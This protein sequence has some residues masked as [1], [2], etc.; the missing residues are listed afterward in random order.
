LGK[1]LYKPVT[2][3]S[4]GQLKAFLFVST[5]EAGRGEKA[6]R[7]ENAMLKDEGSLCS[8]LSVLYLV[9]N[10]KLMFAIRLILP[11]K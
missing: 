11:Y 5:Y 9:V 10:L 1:I 2:K 6:E 8:V 3:I 7:E 4:G